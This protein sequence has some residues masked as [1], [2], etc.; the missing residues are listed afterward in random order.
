[1]TLSKQLHFKVLKQRRQPLNS[2]T[3]Q[4]KDKHKSRHHDRLEIDVGKVGDPI[5]SLRVVSCIIFYHFET[6]QNLVK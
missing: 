1:M 4:L 5:L 3:K 6:T 2:L